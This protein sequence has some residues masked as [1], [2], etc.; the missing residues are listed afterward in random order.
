VD[1]AELEREYANRR[2]TYE[3]VAEEAAHILEDGL[4]KRKIKFQSV[5]KRIK[6]LP[7]FIEKV[8]RRQTDKPF[9]DITDLVG[10]RIVCLLRSDL[11]RIADLIRSSFVVVAEDDKLET[12]PVASF[13]Y[14]GIHFIVKLKGEY[15][16]PRYDGLHSQP[17]EIQVRTIAMDA[18]AAV[19][20]YLDYKTDV[21]VPTALR[22]DFQAL[23]GLF[24]LADTHFEMFYDVRQKSREA[25][26]QLFDNPERAVEEE[27]NYDTLAAL[28]RGRYPDREPA[29]SAHISNL[30]SDLNA[31][32]YKTV[33]SLKNVLDRSANAFEH[34]EATGAPRAHGRRDWADVAAVRLSVAI[35]DSQFRQRTYGAWAADYQLWEARLKN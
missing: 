23:S 30:L 7:S 29:V 33:V 21:D 32:G 10:L 22:K 8:D 26:G 5:L 6:E 4:A 2:R 34:L 31:S 16:G 15:R 18:W 35:A 24:Y 12:Q 19:S 3:R 13:G 20:H 14:L 28:L 1:R 9:E 17:F 11:P 25:A 27:L